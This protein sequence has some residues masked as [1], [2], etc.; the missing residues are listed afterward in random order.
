V[1]EVFFGIDRGET[2]DDVTEAAASTA[3]TD[4]EVRVDLAANLSHAEIELLL[5]QIGNYIREH[6]A[7]TGA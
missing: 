3:T 1:A 2:K 6:P 5:I 4:V 7:S